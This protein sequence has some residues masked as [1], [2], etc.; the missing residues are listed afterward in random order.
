MKTSTGNR[1]DELFREKFMDFTENPPASV[2]EKLKNTTSGLTHF[3]PFWKKGSF[4]ASI[5][6][7]AFIGTTIILI[8]SFSSSNDTTPITNKVT[9]NNLLTSND[10]LKVI[11]PVDNT[12]I[13]TTE[14]QTM[15]NIQTKESAI[16]KNDV[17]NKEYSPI[18]STTNET[19][20]KDNSSI[21]DVTNA[22]DNPFEKTT[23]ENTGNLKYV[24]HTNVKAATC[25]K[26]NGMVT[27]SS[28][29]SN[30]LFYWIDI[31]NE[32]PHSTM[33]NLSSG[34][35]NIKA[36]SDQGVTQN[37]TITVP[38]SGIMRVGFTHYEMT[39]AIGVPVYF[40][41]KSTVDGV[42][43][44]NVE[45]TT[46]KWYFGDGKISTEL[47]PEHMYN[48]MG[49]FTISLVAYSPQGCKDS[50]SINPLYIAGSDIVPANIF[51]P[52][53]DGENDIFI[54]AVQ[55]L[56]SYQLIIFNRNGQTLFSTTNPSQGWD[57]K[58]NHGSELASPGTYYFIVKGVG[59][60]GKI[61]E[62]KRTVDL[63]L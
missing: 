12:I 38:D 11:S 45:N 23:P 59:I 52:N 5:G 30:L 53:G 26:S 15:T 2:L 35:Y 17:I 56:Q 28:N 42:D 13:S 1:F 25:R 60:D 49:P 8:H 62:I 24:I 47:N 40:S 6:I 51:T 32:N 63:K 14:K 9:A 58:I 34:K 22:P 10:N 33:K 21:G 39:Q 54:P 50:S 19:F 3:T 41:N 18:N 46:F 55:A 16:Q 61:I 43:V 44:E 27:L 57:G 4:F 20:N 36:V 7:V 31:D 29:Y 48:S 37:M